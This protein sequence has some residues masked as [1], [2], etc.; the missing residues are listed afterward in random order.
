MFP[1]VQHS[2]FEELTLLEDALNLPK[3]M[4]AAIR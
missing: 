3:R 1:P 4:W 2:I